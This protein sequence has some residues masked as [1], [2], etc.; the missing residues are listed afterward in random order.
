VET[1]FSAWLI[2]FLLGAGLALLEL[3]MPGFIVLFFGLGC[4]ITAAALLLWDL[5][6]T[7]QVTVFIIGSVSSIVLLRRLLMRM[8]QG[9]ASGTS[10]DYDDFP[11]GAH[12]QVAQRITPQVNGRVHYR[13]TLWYAT[14]DE[15]IEVGETAEI[16]RFADNSRQI[17]FV[18]KI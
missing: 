9:R 7:Q 13:G 14:A 1:I 4:W 16:L 2:W 6:A 18:R 8:F 17:Y 3:Q 12:V 10:V 5:S 11:K 15:E